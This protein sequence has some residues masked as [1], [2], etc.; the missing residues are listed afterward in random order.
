MEDG[1]FL[2]PAPRRCAFILRVLLATAVAALS[3]TCKY[4]EVVVVEPAATG[5]GAL[6]LSI[7]PDGEDAAVAREL[8]WTSGIPGAEVTI[9]AGGGDTAVGPPLATLVTDSGAQV[10]VPDL[11]DGKYFVQVHRLLTPAETARLAAGEDVVGFM[12]QAV[13]DRGSTTVYVPASHRRSIVIS[14]WSFFPEAIPNVGGYEYGGYLELTNNSDTTVYLDGLVIG[15][16][17][18]QAEDDPRSPCAT[19]EYLS[20]DPDGVWARRF[21]SLPGAGHTYPLAPG[22]SAVVATDA[23]DHSQ[24]SPEGV[25][26]SHADFES[27][28][29]ADVDNPGVPNTVTIGPLPWYGEHGLLFFDQL[30]E[31]VFVALPVDT[32]AL[33]KQYGPRT[34]WPYDRVPRAKI[35]DVVALL[36]TWSAFTYPFCPQLVHSNFDRYRAR[37]M[38]SHVDDEG[39]AGRWSIQRKVAYTRA[40][41][42]K[43]LQATR[44][45]AA[46]LFLGLRTPF[47]VP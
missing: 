29:S 12:A 28:G 9:T 31:V 19:T 20:N 36:S 3:A 1:V 35:L 10:S 26:L 38:T 30:A 46:D 7:Q 5:H 44:N 11:P 18:G 21:D 2:A 22:A 24:V 4:G 6:R 47:R 14:E 33:P 40:D 39:N 15:E 27:I 45:S 16:A 43:I 25:D 34:A 17:Y 8:G 23:I 42:R 32:A 41:G 37:L 13:V